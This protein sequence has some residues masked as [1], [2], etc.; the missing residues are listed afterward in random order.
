MAGNISDL[1]SRLK[2]PASSG[3]EKNGSGREKVNIVLSA[4]WKQA[5][6]LKVLDWILL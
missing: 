6:F 3:A 5:Y 1:P 4:A 2:R